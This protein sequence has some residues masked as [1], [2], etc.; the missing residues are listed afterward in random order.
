[1]NQG[2]EM[3]YNFLLDRVQDGKQDEAKALLEE[4]FV[5]Q[6]EGTFTREYAAEVQMKMT[7]ILKPKAMQE[8]M[9]AMAHFNSQ[10]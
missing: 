10:Q 2:Q 4:S 9:A 3:F 8:V 5:K 7:A 6:A 1:M